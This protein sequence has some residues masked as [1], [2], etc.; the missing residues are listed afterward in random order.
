MHPKQ[1][2]LRRSGL[3]FSSWSGRLSTL[4]CGVRVARST[5]PKQERNGAKWKRT[6]IF[7]SLRFIWI[8]GPK[9]IR[10]LA[11]LQIIDAITATGKR[12]CDF[13]ILRINWC[14]VPKTKVVFYR[15]ENGACPFIEW[16]DALPAKIQDKCFLRLERLCELG[17]ELR[18]PE[19]DFLRDGIHEL[20]ISLRGLHYW[21]LYFFH[22]TTAA[23]SHGVVKERVVPPKE[24]DQAI[25]RKMRFE[26]NPANHTYQ[27]A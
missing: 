24:I 11:L 13:A 12:S 8:G 15:E 23:V 4:R 2:S 3:L 6:S 20:R 7:E 10:T 19:A 5:R 9:G 27:E 18:R 14:G 17:H 16:F 26:S 22:G 21:I 1:E 25:R